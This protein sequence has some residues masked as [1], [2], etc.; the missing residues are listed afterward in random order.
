MKWPVHVHTNDDPLGAAL[1]IAALIFCASLALRGPVELIGASEGATAALLTF[2]GA[3]VVFGLERAWESRR[4]RK[5]RNAMERVAYVRL[6]GRVDRFR[7]KVRDRELALIE[8]L[9]DPLNAFDVPMHVFESFTKLRWTIPSDMAWDEAALLDSETLFDLDTVGRIA[10]RLNEVRPTETATRLDGGDWVISRAVADDYDAMVS[11]L[12]VSLDA[13]SYSIAQ[14]L[15]TP[16][17]SA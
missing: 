8:V 7:A 10:D 3:V 2:I 15:L 16:R 9:S 1:A 5:K 14:R 6:S 4:N 12:S 13:L 17:G 11:D